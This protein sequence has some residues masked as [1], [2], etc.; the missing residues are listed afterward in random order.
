M[1]AAHR[2]QPQSGERLVDLIAHPTNAG[3]RALRRSTD[4]ARCSFT[5]STLD[6]NTSYLSEREHPDARARHQHRREAHH[7]TES[8]VRSTRPLSPAG[9]TIPMRSQPR[10]NAAAGMVSPHTATERAAGFVNG[11][12]EDQLHHQDNQRERAVNEQVAQPTAPHRA[13]RRRPERIHARTRAR[14]TRAVRGPRRPRRPRSP[15][16]GEEPSA[17]G[18][19]RHRPPAPPRRPPRGGCE[20]APPARPT[21]A[22]GRAVEPAAPVRR[23]APPGRP[24]GPVPA[25]PR[26][27]PRRAGPRPAAGW[28]PG[29][30]PG[31][32]GIG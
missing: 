15:W 1:A 6:M 13:G 20:P 21:R 8:A 30:R 29:S 9:K 32:L 17:P 2:G 11:Q 16:R 22:A 10:A 24:C 18:P 7:R 23:Q 19:D 27:W 3:H 14:R 5:S 31:V 4:V 12:V 28:P 26:R 25:P